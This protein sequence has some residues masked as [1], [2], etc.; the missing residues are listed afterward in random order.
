MKVVK[1]DSFKAFDVNH[2]NKQ[3]CPKC[4]SDADTDRIPRGWLFKEFLPWLSVKH[5]ICYRCKRKFYKIDHK[6]IPN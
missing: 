6:S 1:I 5:Y 2:F 4:K 3:V